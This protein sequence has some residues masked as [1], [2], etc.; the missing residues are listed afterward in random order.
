MTFPGAAETMAALSRVVLET[1]DEEAAAKVVVDCFGA[2]EDKFAIRECQK[3]IARID[4]VL[5]QVKQA[6]EKRDWK[7]GSAVAM[8]FGISVGATQLEAAK[9]A[10]V[11]LSTMVKDLQPG[12]FC[13]PIAD[14][15]CQ[16]LVTMAKDLVDEVSRLSKR[17]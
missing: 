1:E 11:Q 15:F 7:R 8:A 12:S 4:V 5:G 16:H 2:I 13:E 6:V 14:T 10:M 9:P 17:V 3:A